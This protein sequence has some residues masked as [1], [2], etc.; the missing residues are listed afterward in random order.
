MKKRKNRI[1]ALIAAASVITAILLSGCNSTGAT[2]SAETSATQSSQSSTTVT[3]APSE[4]GATDT[5][6][7]SGTSSDPAPQG[8]PPTSETKASENEESSAPLTES[9]PDT[10]VTDPPAPETT[11]PPETTTNQTTTPPET[12]TPVTTAPIPE[13]T[14]TQK[15]DTKPP[16]SAKPDPPY[17]RETVASGKTVF[18]NEYALIDASNSSEGYVMVKLKEATDGNFKVLVDAVDISVRYTFSLANDGSY[19]VI[20]ITEGSGNYKIIVL[21]QTSANKGTTLLKE[22]FKVNIS[23]EFSAFLTPTQY[24][25]YD[26]NSECVKLASTITAGMTELQKIEAVYEY[27]TENIDYVSTAEN[28][29]NGYTPYPDRTLKNKSGICFDY[30]SLMTAML[31]SQRLPTKVVV[32]YAGDIYHAWIS[33]Y[34]KGSGWIDGIISFDGNK[35]NRMDPTFAASAKDEADYRNLIDYISN[36]S[37][38]RDLYYY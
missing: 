11:L 4:T 31:R 38:Y 24:C 22:E 2:S 15:P 3:S 17:I 14:T 33:V 26:A 16:A 19:E 36:N 5:P 28:A 27:V 1:S 13:T 35:W 9:T 6:G 30:A 20:P 12:T 37:N 21:K 32:G 25:M 7:T 8:T 18:Q 23:D 29:A 34:V 10:S